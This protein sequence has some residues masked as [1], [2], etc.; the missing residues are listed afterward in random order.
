[1][2]FKEN[3][4][5]LYR[6]DGSKVINITYCRD[7]GNRYFV[8]G[9][10]KTI[11]ETLNEKWQEKQILEYKAIHN[12]YYEQE[13][14]TQKTIFDFTDWRGNI[15]D[16]NTKHDCDYRKWTK[17]SKHTYW[18]GG[19]IERTN[20]KFPR[21]YADERRK[22]RN[23]RSFSVDVAN[24]ENERQY[25][26]VW[27]W[28]H[29]KIRYQMT[30][31]KEVTEFDGIKDL[32]ERLDAIHKDMRNHTNDY[33]DA[34]IVKLS[35]DIEEIEWRG[36]CMIT[37]NKKQLIEFL[38]ER[39]MAHLYYGHDDESMVQSLKDYGIISGVIYEPV[40]HNDTFRGVNKASNY[41]VLYVLNEEG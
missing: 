14:E 34:N 39:D 3:E 31:E 17:A 11:Y 28:W 19:T 8:R 9:L 30:F 35:D 20:G 37:L 15:K 22:R 27:K 23:N 25:Y 7:C 24:K 36:G 38:D 41:R 18:V 26:Y 10:A 4:F 33:T 1:M 2:A 16:E 13:L 32:D 12:L 40:F 29:M 5:Y 6:E 21:R